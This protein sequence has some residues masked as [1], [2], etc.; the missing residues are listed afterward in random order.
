MCDNCIT[1]SALLC[2]FHPVYYIHVY[3]YRYTLSSPCRTAVPCKLYSIPLLEHMHGECTVLYLHTYISYLS[4]LAYSTC[5]RG[6]SDVRSLALYCL[7]SLVCL[8]YFM[9]SELSSL[10]WQADIPEVKLPRHMIRHIQY[11]VHTY[12]LGD[13]A[14]KKKKIHCAAGRYLKDKLLVT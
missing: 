9:T 1:L 7:L 2:L 8:L 4:V 3:I 14:I 5:D 13:P 11:R 10:L 12:D 6:R